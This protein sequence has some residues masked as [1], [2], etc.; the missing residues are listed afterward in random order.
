MFGNHL[1]NPEDIRPGVSAGRQGAVAH[2]VRSFSD[3]KRFLVEPAFPDWARSTGADKSHGKGIAEVQRPHG[4]P[5]RL[6]RAFA[7]DRA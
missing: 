7:D 5:C 4:D 2:P 3:Q 1:G 6:R